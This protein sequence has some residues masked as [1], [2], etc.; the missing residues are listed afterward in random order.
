MRSPSSPRAWLRWAA[1]VLE[2]QASPFSPRLDHVPRGDFRLRN[3]GE[4]ALDVK[5]MLE[6]ASA[7]CSRNGVG[8]ELLVDYYVREASWHSFTQTE[9]RAIRKTALRF[10]EALREA[11]FLPGQE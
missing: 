2:A 8:Y 6:R 4:T 10:T 5:I 1:R 11:G 3:S 9:Q 7:K